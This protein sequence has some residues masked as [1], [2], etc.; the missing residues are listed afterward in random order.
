MSIFIRSTTCVLFGCIPNMVWFCVRTCC[1]CMLIRYI[2]S[3]TPTVIPVMILFLN[4]RIRCITRTLSRWKLMLLLEWLLLWLVHFGWL[5]L[6][7]ILSTLSL[8]STSFITPRVSTSSTSTLVSSTAY[9]RA[10]WKIR[11]SAREHVEAVGTCQWPYNATCWSSSGCSTRDGAT[12][13]VDIEWE[14]NHSR[15]DLKCHSIWTWTEIRESALQ[16]EIRC[17]C[18]GL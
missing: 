18:K 17:C 12:V 4:V 13:D 2:V 5:I 14:C 6:L 8:I 15:V 16:L 9:W 3:T 11:A 10:I 7:Y 1:W